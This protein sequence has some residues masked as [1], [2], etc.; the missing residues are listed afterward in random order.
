[1]VGLK[2][3]FKS[4]RFG[5]DWRHRIY[6]EEI[7]PAEDGVTYPR[8]LKGKR[9]CPPEDSG[10]ACRYPDLLAILT[11]PEHGGHDSRKECV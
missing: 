3:V 11:N 10:G 5:D 6:F 9:A 8:C 7:K 1:M 4:K 2:W